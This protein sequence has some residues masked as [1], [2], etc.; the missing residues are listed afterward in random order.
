MNFDKEFSTKWNLFSYNVSFTFDQLFLGINSSNCSNVKIQITGYQYELNVNHFK[1]KLFAFFMFAAFKER[2]QRP[3]QYSR[4]YI[5]K[6]Q[7]LYFN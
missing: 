3:V 6:F 7:R 2:L 5:G 1:T 4:S